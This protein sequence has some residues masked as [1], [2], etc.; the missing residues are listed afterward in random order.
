VYALHH[1][2]LF[3]LTCICASALGRPLPKPLARVEDVDTDAA[4]IR[5]SGTLAAAPTPATAA[6]AAAA[7]SAAR[8]GHHWR[9]PRDD[10]FA[11]VLSWLHGAC[12]AWRARQAQR[13]LR[14]AALPHATHRGGSGSR[15]A[16]TPQA[17]RTAFAPPTAQR[18]ES[19]VDCQVHGSAAAAAADTA[20]A[21][22][23]SRSG[24]PVQQLRAGAL[25]GMSQEERSFAQAEWFKVVRA[26]ELAKT[27]QEEAKSEFYICTVLGFRWA[28]SCKRRV[29]DGTACS[30]GPC[31]LQGAWA[32]SRAV[33][34]EPQRQW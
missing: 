5:L 8:K 24:P 6:E 27:T 26:V 2:S 30:S 11:A 31:A 19:L 25:G 12:A 3:S 4:F 23:V 13:G 7:A 32:A 20:A 17:E 22:D 29:L 33:M 1:D 18:H 28:A 15:P 9:R 21:A 34:R 16:S 14:N 10:D